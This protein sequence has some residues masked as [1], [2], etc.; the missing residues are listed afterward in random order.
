MGTPDGIDPRT[1]ELLVSGSEKLELSRH[2]LDELDLRL[3]R[4]AELLG[5]AEP[6]TTSEPRRG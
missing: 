1:E 6:P 3:E 5:A 4:G 2:I